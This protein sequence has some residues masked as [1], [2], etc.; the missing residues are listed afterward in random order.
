M[1]W[2]II[3]IHAYNNKIT[4]NKYIKYWGKLNYTLLNIINILINI[5]KIYLKLF[6]NII[7][8]IIFL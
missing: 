2:F 4:K 6:I 1:E 3:I 7:I 5:L 8:E